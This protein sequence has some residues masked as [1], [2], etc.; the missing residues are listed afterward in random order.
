MD[1]AGQ[2]NQQVQSP[3]VLHNVLYYPFLLVLVRFNTQFA[4]PITMDEEYDVINHP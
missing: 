2:P 1:Q 4:Q 3:T